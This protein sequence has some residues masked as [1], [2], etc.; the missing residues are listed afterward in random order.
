[1]SPI[2]SQNLHMSKECSCFKYFFKTFSKKNKI[3]LIK[4]Q[5]S[6]NKISILTQKQF[7]E[8]KSSHS[9]TEKFYK[10]LKQNEI[11]RKKAYSKQSL[12]A[13]EVIQQI[14]TNI[15]NQ[16]YNSY[17]PLASQIGSLLK[18]IDVSDV[19]D[20]LIK[21]AANEVKKEGKE[22]EVVSPYIKDFRIDPTTDKGQT[23]LAKIAQISAARGVGV[24][25]HLHH[26]KINGKTPEGLKVLEKIARLDAR[27][28]FRLSPHIQN[29][30]IDGKTEEGRS[31]LLK[32]AA[33]DSN[34]NYVLKYQTISPYL[35]SYGIDF[36]TKEGKAFL[37]RMAEI[38][39]GVCLDLERFGF[40]IHSQEGQKKIIELAYFH[41]HKALGALPYEIIK[42]FPIKKENKQGVWLEIAK[43][44]ALH[45]PI[46][47]IKNLFNYD[48]DWTGKEACLARLKILG[49][50]I[51]Q[52]G[53]KAYRQYEALCYFA[54]KNED[55]LN[56]LNQYCKSDKEN[57]ESNYLVLNQEINTYLKH[58]GTY[59]KIKSQ[60]EE[61]LLNFSQALPNFPFSQLLFVIDK[62]IILEIDKETLIKEVMDIDNTFLPKEKLQ[63]LIEES[64]LH[65]LKT[66]ALWVISTALC[67]SQIK[68][69]YFFDMKNIL[70]HLMELPDPH[71][72]Y[73][74]SDLLIK[75]YIQQKLEQVLNSYRRLKKDH[76]FSSPIAKQNFSLLILA[77]AIGVQEGQDIFTLINIANRLS[78]LKSNHT[79][80][81]KNGSKV[82]TLLRTI[83]TINTNLTFCAK[84]KENLLNKITSETTDLVNQ[85]CLMITMLLDSS[86]QEQIKILINSNQFYNDL[87]NIYKTSITD[88]IPNDII[89][90]PNQLNEFLETFRNPNL[91]LEYFN[92]LKKIEMEN[93]EKKIVEESIG[94]FWK[95]IFNNEFPIYR[96]EGGKHLKHVF[97]N[98]EDLKKK[99]MEYREYP[100]KH[101]QGSEK[102]NIVN[103]DNLND[104]LACTTEIQ[105]S[106]LNI[107]G[108]YNNNKC[109][110]NYI[111]DGKIRLI[112]IKDMQGT[113][114]A[115]AIIRILLTKDENL[116]QENPILFL[117]KTYPEKADHLM[118]KGI[119][120][121]A[122]NTAKELNLPLLI[123]QEIQPIER[124]MRIPTC[125]YLHPV[126]SL[127]TRG[128]PFEYIDAENGIYGNE[129][130]EFVHDDPLHICQILIT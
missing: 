33:Y 16:N 79:L 99:W 82:K 53:L 6:K 125:D 76:S 119:I 39:V 8:N 106:C 1:M 47:T 52:G 107:K 17:K 11:L 28:G 117:E 93:P 57:E 98:R 92:Q 15:E 27:N 44:A 2:Y 88:I 4:Q 94:N 5:T 95:K 45:Y 72:R 114:K 118:K 56:S 80:M 25:S 100:L 64:N 110:F 109:L 70:E 32:I 62:R 7:E 50:A 68:E 128:Y 29:Y 60:G 66:T 24:S 58:L 124:E 3:E 111:D 75:S 120:E 86:K 41:T 89:V 48:I 38:E 116:Q 127:G 42:R 96:Y 97:K 21:L 61:A 34:K 63:K 14:K 129:E 108:G 83:V 12:T 59:L 77:L 65:F 54:Y 51:L 84:E 26:Y 85:T 105:G 102:L 37:L 23:A 74:F 20:D 103:T 18:N 10:N 78:K 35:L 123:K 112:A 104:L 91:L 71:L 46:N 73:I 13:R 30:G 130:L 81:L 115:R 69:E 43:S 55:K 49:L 126:Y 19:Q 90:E 122:K 36:K 9:I 22:G 67:L 121:M 40:D 31:L 113:I 101:S 87:M